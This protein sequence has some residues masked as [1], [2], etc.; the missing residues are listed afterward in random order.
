[1]KK[2]NYLIAAIPGCFMTMVVIAYILQAKEGLQ[3]DGYISN[4][5]GVVLG[6]VLMILLIYYFKR[7][8]IPQNKIA[9]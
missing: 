5:I 4:I 8:K 2:K 7:N 1:M 3:L 9:I 6:I